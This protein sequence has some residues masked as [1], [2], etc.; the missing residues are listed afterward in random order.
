MHPEIDR[1]RH[2]LAESR[3]PVT[4]V[5]HRCPADLREEIVSRAR[6]LRQQGHTLRR[7]AE[8][9]AVPHKTL[10]NWLQRYQGTLRPVTVASSYS[11]AP[12][13]SGGI[14]I[15]TPQGYRIEGL[16]VD[17]AIALVRA[18]A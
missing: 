15:V 12:G 11:M 7:I 4:G 1:L 6:V 16:D 14:R 17:E 9:F 2:A 8:T 5:R 3:R 13:S 18:L 10:A